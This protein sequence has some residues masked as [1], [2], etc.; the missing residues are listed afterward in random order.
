VCCFL[1]ACYPCNETKDITCFCKRTKITVP[2]GK[3][4]VT[5]PP[6]CNLPCTSVLFVCF[7]VC[8]RILSRQVLGLVCL[9]HELETYTFGC[10]VYVKAVVWDSKR[11]FDLT[12]PNTVLTLSVLSVAKVALF[13]LSL[14]LPWLNVLCCRHPPNCHHPKRQK[15]RCHFG[16]CP[17]CSQICDLQLPNCQ[18]SCPVS[19]HDAV[20]VKFE[21]KVS[22]ICVCVWS[23]TIINMNDAILWSNLVMLFC[24]K[25]MIMNVVLAEQK[26]RP[27]GSSDHLHRDCEE[28]LP[29]VSSAVACRMYGQTRG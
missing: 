27:L 7:I 6:R 24:F 1:G 16:E 4:K 25:F 26:A 5:K 3:E 29:S 11:G 20:K 15:H 18:H 13:S 10:E 9:M 28:G 17:P 19:C 12:Y 23:K 8:L 21:D 22:P 14:I 2:C